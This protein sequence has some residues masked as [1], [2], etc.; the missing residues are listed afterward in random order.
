MG[1]LKLYLYKA[2]I[3]VLTQP[4]CLEVIGGVILCRAMGALKGL[5]AVGRVVFGWLYKLCGGEFST[6]PTD[7]SSHILTV[8]DV[9]RYTEVVS[10]LDHLLLELD[11]ARVNV[12][13]Y[14][15]GENFSL[16]NPMFKLS[17]TY[18]AL[19]PG[20]IATAQEMNN[21]S[22]STIPVFFRPLFLSGPSE[23]AGV[24]EEHGCKKPGTC[25]LR[26]IPLR[27][28]SY[29]RETLKIG[30]LRLI[31]DKFGIEKMFACPLVS[32]TG[33]M[34]GAM[35]IHYHDQTGADERVK[36][37]FCDICKTQQYL[38]TILYKK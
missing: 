14:H 13:Q 38:Q 17:V 21:V 28:I 8:G 1:E 2:L 33:A 19:A 7:V 10:M 26:D 15:N 18:E 9:S 3:S 4:G 35:T 30:T 5:K 27:L 34:I 22:V 24:K 23:I 37:A 16:S 11:C 12:V 6:S 32:P 31:M 20:F 25:K 29:T 36:K